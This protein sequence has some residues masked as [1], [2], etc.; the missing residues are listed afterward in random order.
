MEKL[1]RVRGKMCRSAVCIVVHPP[2]G[3]GV[4]LEHLIK[5]M[6]RKEGGKAVIVSG[7]KVF[8]CFFDVQTKLRSLHRNASNTM[9]PRKT[10][11]F[12]LKDTVGCHIFVGITRAGTMTKT[13]NA[14]ACA[15]ASLKA[16][17]FVVVVDVQNL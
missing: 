14:G 1:V 8:C 12:L 13:I 11:R 16:D 10:T 2:L 5:K 6:L 4:R 9:T 3:R 15:S 17:G 7:C